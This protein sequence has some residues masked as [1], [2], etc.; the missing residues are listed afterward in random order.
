MPT[1]QVIPPAPPEFHP[2]FGYFWPAAQ[3]RRLMRVGLMSTAFGLLFGAI[4]VLAMPPRP[5]PDLAH[6]A[7]ALSAVSVDEPATTEAAPS[8]A[9]PITAASATAAPSSAVGTVMAP[10]TAVLANEPGAAAKSCKEQTW[11]YLEGTC[12]NNSARKR[13]PARV[14][15]PETSAQSAPAQVVQAPEITA[16]AKTQETSKVSSRREKK[17][18]ARQRERDRESVADRERAGYVDPRSAYASPYV[19][20]T[21]RREGER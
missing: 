2:E 17:A 8:A 7:T 5:D 13:Q 16:A 6:A 14:L 19:Y 9:P 20:E 12:L 4:A 3:S 10:A 21:P 15:R 1:P 11:P 18:K